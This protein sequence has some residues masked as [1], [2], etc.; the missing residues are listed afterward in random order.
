MHVQVQSVLLLSYV[1]STMSGTYRCGLNYNG[2]IVYSGTVSIVVAGKPISL[3]INKYFTNFGFTNF[4]C[5]QIK[6]TVDI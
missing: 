6:R 4:G 1:Q 2:P 3:Y 5:N